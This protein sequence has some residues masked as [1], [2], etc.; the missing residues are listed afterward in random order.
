MEQKLVEKFD[1][2]AVDSGA[3]TVLEQINLV[4]HAKIIV[5]GH[6]AALTNL[7]FAG[8]LEHMVELYVW[9][10]QTFLKAA[11]GYLG[12][13]HHYLRGDPAGSPP[14]TGDYA[15]WDNQDYTVPVDQLLTLVDAI[16]GRPR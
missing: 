11:C 8:K 2:V 4:K 15:R 9:H 13:G 5:G 1:F 10:T 6:G 16:A 7:I 14:A 12:A 3:M